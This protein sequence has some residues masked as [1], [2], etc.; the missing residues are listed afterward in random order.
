MEFVI[1]GHPPKGKDKIKKE[2]LSMG[3]KVVTK[4]KN[5]VMAIIS[6]SEEVEKMNNRMQEAESEQIHVVSDDFLDEAKN[7]VGKIPDLVIKKSIC[8]WG[9]DVS[10]FIQNL[11]KNR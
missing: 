3:G 7:C 2:V 8:S 11:S 10:I 9:T 4:I 6:T 5:T 1:L